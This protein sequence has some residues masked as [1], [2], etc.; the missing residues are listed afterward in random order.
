MPAEKSP[1]VVELDLDDL[2]AHCPN[3]HM[4]IWSSHQRVYL[5]I[6]QFGEG[7]CPYC[8]TIYRL[9]PGVIVRPHPSDPI[10]SSHDS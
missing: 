8:G 4:P 10:R 7:Q 6:Y 2:P 9:R 3:P 5:D 1:P